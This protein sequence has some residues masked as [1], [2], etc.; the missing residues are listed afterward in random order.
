MDF[1]PRKREGSSGFL[2]ALALEAGL[3]SLPDISV[4]ETG[5]PDLVVILS[6]VPSVYVHEKRRSGCSTDLCSPND[7]RYR[8]DTSEVAELRLNLLPV[9]LNATAGEVLY[10]LPHTD[11]LFDQ[12]RQLEQLEDSFHFLRRDDRIYLWAKPGKTIPAAVSLTR[13]AT[14]AASAAPSRVLAH[15]VREAAADC[16][17]SDQHGFER[18][19]GAFFDP[20]RL[21]RRRKNLT[22][23]G[24]ADKAGIFPYVMLQA[25]VL[26]HELATVALVV[27]VGLVSRLDVPLRDLAAAQIDIQGMPVDWSHAPNCSCPNPSSV[28]RAGKVVGGDPDGTVEIR[29]RFELTKRSVAARCLVLH[30]NQRIVEQYLSNMTTA[31]VA[32]SIVEGTKRFHAPDEQWKMVEWTR[33]LL[34]GFPVFASSTVTLEEPITASPG[35][36]GDVRVLAPLSSPQLNFH[37]GSPSLGTQAARG[38]TRYGPYDKLTA[39]KSNINALVLCPKALSSQGERL[40]RAL[41]D[42]IDRFAGIKERFQLD[43]LDISVC[44]FDQDD[45]SG[46]ASAAEKATRPAAD[47]STPDIV[48][49]VTREAD[50]SAG[51]GCNRYLAGKAVLA[52]AGVA[53]QAVKA[54]TIN[55][56]DNSFQWTADQIALQ[57]YS[58]IGN[59]PYVLHDPGGVPE[60]VLGVGRSDIYRANGPEQLFGAAA[61]F[62]QDGDFL[63]AGST[64]PVVGRDEY[65]DKLAELITDFIGRFTQTL[66][67]DPQRVIIHLFKRTGSKERLAVER[68]LAGRNMEWALVHVNRD[69]PLWLVEAEHGHVTPAP[70]GSVVEIGEGDRL[71]A[72]GNPTSIYRKERN[73]H[74][75]RLTLDKESTYRDMDRITEQV[76]GFTAV[77]GRSFSTTHEPSTIL[78]GRLLA[79]QV[80]RLEPYGF[81]PERSIGIGD[82]PW[83]L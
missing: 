19:H 18:L 38:L 67:A 76:F 42:G 1:V 71:L 33:T 4:A 70:I 21:F 45:A 31:N 50:R 29:G 20:V 55:Q 41:E 57:S 58:K 74:P 47:G 23:A 73:S 39:R 80:G 34:Q 81:N 17:T 22:G 75:L 68:A 30:P 32:R 79:E 14:I 52:N 66:G 9:V 43:S 37:Y 2:S 25:V 11:E 83:F 16:L 77:S 5:S 10:H 15:A 26:R 6:L 65:K 60:L 8:R 40:K 53:S 63:F 28:G 7:G 69:T 44:T 56:A 46:Y 12:L 49:I 13:A 59:I 24:I 64:A 61:A 3:A 72:T 35:S 51:P 78:Y 54:E 62:R 82:R 36:T 27:D 48:Y